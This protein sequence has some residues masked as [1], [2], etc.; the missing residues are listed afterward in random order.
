MCVFPS[1][2]CLLDVVLSVYLSVCL[3]VLV[4]FVLFV[5]LYMVCLSVCL[6]VC[7]KSACHLF[8]RFIICLLV[9]CHLVRLSVWRS[10]YLFVC[11]YK[12]FY[13]C[14][15]ICCLS[16]FVMF[17]SLCDVFLSV[18]LSYHL[19]PSVCMMFVSLW[20]VFLSVSLSLSTMWHPYFFLDFKTTLFILLQSTLYYHRTYTITFCLSCS[21]F[22]LP[23]N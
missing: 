8:V 21:S 19:C 22:R 12:S 10:F 20:D 3:S 16:V 9:V 23:K 4:V 13:F 5:L 1:V 7:C 17:V 15:S 14:L 6:S 2:G 18:S 11:Y